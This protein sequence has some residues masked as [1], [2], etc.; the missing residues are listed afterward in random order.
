MFGIQR[1]WQRGTGK[2]SEAYCIRCKAHR[3][4]IRVRYVEHKNSKRLEGICT[5]C[6]AKTSSYVAV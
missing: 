1:L 2:F 6:T 5:T 4:V 3:Q